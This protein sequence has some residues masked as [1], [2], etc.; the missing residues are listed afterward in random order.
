MRF[1]KFKMTISLMGNERHDQTSASHQSVEL[2]AAG[3]GDVFRL[4]P[5]KRQLGRRDAF[6]DH[7]TGTDA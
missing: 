4:L 6:V 1:Y 5:Y 2:K 7:R 3:Y